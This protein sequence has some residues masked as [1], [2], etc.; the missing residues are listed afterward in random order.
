M[1]KTKDTNS[2]CNVTRVTEHKNDRYANQSEKELAK[3]LIRKE[4]GEK[5]IRKHILHF[6]R[7]FS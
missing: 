1:H 6:W 5:E 2:A 3:R 7:V 4:G